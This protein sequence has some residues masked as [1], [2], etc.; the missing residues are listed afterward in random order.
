MSEVRVPP[1]VT[2]TFE[3]L[4]A[5]VCQQAKLDDHEWA[6]T[7]RE[8]LTHLQNRWREG[9]ALNLNTDTA[10]QRALDLFGNAEVVAKSLRR[11]W[12]NRLLFHENRRLKRILVFLSASV[13]G[14][15]LLSTSMVMLNVASDG[16]KSD[17]PALGLLAG[18]F[19]HPFIVLGSLFVV[20]W[21]PVGWP[22]LLRQLLLIRHILWVMVVLGCWNVAFI[23]IRVLLSLFQ[24]EWW[25]AALP[26]VVPS[27]G[28]GI[29]GAACFW[30]EMVGLSGRG[31]QSAQEAMAFQM[32]R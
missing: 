15:A 14:V 31:K 4:V 1:A 23:P 11:P 26:I 10:T 2:F 27:I 3:R 21:Q 6:L 7:A 24:V 17:I 32:I 20:K 8:L 22:F 25:P 29:L 28:F 19:V 18:Y 13:W 12:W 30:S 5:D 9:D 16:A